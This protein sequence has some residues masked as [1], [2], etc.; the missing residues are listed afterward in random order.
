MTPRLRF[1]LQTLT[2][3][4]SLAVQPPPSS[5]FAGRIDHK[6]VFPPAFGQ[7]VG[8]PNEWKSVPETEVQEGGIGSIGDPST[9]PI[10]PPIDDEILTR[11]SWNQTGENESKVESG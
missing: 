1:P 7:I 5:N 11:R 6:E 3:H 2:G 8:I 4:S 10:T 9:L